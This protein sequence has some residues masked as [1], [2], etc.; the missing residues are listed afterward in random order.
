MSC[1]RSLKILLGLW[2]G[3]GVLRRR[4]RN[5]CIIFA[6]HRVVDQRSYDQC[7]FQKSIQVTSGG[8]RLFLK[9]LKKD[10]NVVPLSSLLHTKKKEDPD[11]M[12]LAVITFD[13]GWRDNYEL[14]FPII[15]QEQVPATIF[16]T[17]D[18]IDN[19]FGFWWQSLGEVLSDKTLS[20]VCRRKI[21]EYMSKI[22][23]NGG[24]DMDVFANVDASIELLKTMYSY[25]ALAITEKILELAQGDTVRS[26]ALTWEQCRAM[27][28]RGVTFGSHT[29]SHP[30]LTCLDDHTLE[31]EL[32]QS[33][34]ILLENRVPYV[35]AV[36]YPFGDFNRRV[37][38]RAARYYQL[39]L[40]T[41]SGAV[42]C[43][44]WEA[45][46]LPRINISEDVAENQSLLRYRLLK[47]TFK[48]Y[49]P[50]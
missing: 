27:G 35:N 37:M 26:Q 41:L 49:I 38:N 16:L 21:S 3:R 39:G 20:S 19:D 46:A 13:D 34:N 12:P 33:R 42:E 32:T 29:L 31:K 40:T 11:D 15:G 22:L 23:A 9:N 8:F 1:P 47:A 10:F 17:T 14:G 50:L 45:M 36:C 44:R 30:R 48:R 25:K 4:L 2:A 7:S 43:G 6:A 18:Y 5:R 24:N 28:S